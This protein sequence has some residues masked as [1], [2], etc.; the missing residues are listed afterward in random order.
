M[1]WILV[2]LLISIIILLV[3]T[4]SIAVN[5]L[6]RSTRAIQLVMK[7]SYPISTTA[8]QIGPVY[9]VVNPTKIGGKQDNFYQKITNAC[10]AAG[11]PEPIFLETTP[12]NPGTLQAK[13]AVQAGASLVLSAGGDGTL[14]AVAHGLAGTS[15]CLGILPLGTG[16][17]LARNLNL[18]VDNLDRAIDVALTGKTTGLDVGRVK[19]GEKIEPFLVMGGLGFDGELMRDVKDSLKNSLGWG[20]YLISGV[21]RAHR[22]QISVRVACGGVSRPQVTK[23]QTLLFVSCGDLPG[24]LS[25]IPE[26]NPHDGWLDVLFL[27]VRGG[28]FGW[29]EVIS[30]IVMRALGAAS[31]LPELISRMRVVRSR[32]IQVTCLDGPQEVQVDGDAIGRFKE[33]EVDLLYQAVQLRVP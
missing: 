1:F 27:E 14:R 2:I 4:L 18:P 10:L 26:A 19:I 15:S 25:L 17:L 7:Q 3:V 11:Y 23:L 28:W 13:E 8:L 5:A 30:R 32:S 20:A 16:N 9:V 21:T 33:L 22:P 6:Q 31:S 29:L 12:E 24:G